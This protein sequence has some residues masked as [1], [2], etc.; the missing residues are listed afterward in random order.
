MKKSERKKEIEKRLGEEKKN[1]KL[2]KVVRIYSQN[3]EMNNIKSLWD[4][5]NK[6]KNLRQ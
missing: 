4:K 5:R 1:K 2:L 6:K 3:K